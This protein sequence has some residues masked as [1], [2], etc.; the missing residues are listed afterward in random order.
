[1][2][3]ASSIMCK[4]INALAVLFLS[5]GFTVSA[6]NINSPYS[7]YGLGDILPSQNILT[8]GMGGIGTA[9]YDYRSVNFLNPASYGQLQTVMLDFG[10]EV[11]NLTIRALNPTRKYSNASPIISYLNLGIPL[12]KKKNIK[13]GG[14]EPLLGMVVGLRPM[15][16]VNYKIQR[17][18]K[19]TTGTLNDSVGT[20]FEGTGGSQQVYTG[21]GLKLKDLTIGLN[22]G[23][24]FGSK[25][26]STR[27]IFINDTVPYYKSNDQTTSN[28]NGFLF[29]AGAQYTFKL[30]K[31]MFL[32]VGAQ[33][34]WQQ[35]V[36]GNRD[37]IVETFDY[38]ANSATYR[39]D[40]VYAEKDV[41]G[42]VIMPAS[43]S[44]G[45]ILD[46]Q[47]KWSVGADYVSTKWTNHKFFDDAPDPLQDSW[48]MR[49]G[50]QLF[51]TPGKSYW[52]NVAYRTGFS[53]GKDYVKVGNELPK[54]T[55]SVGAGLP[56]RNVPYTNQSTIIN[57]AL[58]FGQ[59]GND[60]N[61][62]K[63]SFF[64]VS[65]GLSMSD[66]WFIKRKYD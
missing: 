8:R 26:F 20:I 3:S 24:L 65:V 27:R 41:K 19:L 17:I 6:Q 1:M 4:R 52:S 54:W 51:P 28:Y 63:E 45:A 40:S 13:T 10:V 57:T 22:I 21:F 30:N 15:T 48:E 43:F 62:V 35:T 46:N 38:D 61:S 7:R 14:R 49:I 44:I 18:E 50:G 37:V 42:D 60:K 11:D 55:F 29:N 2:Q 32:R 9:Y 39:I 12:I 23:Y 36:R 31:D 33:G 25:D 56:L 47:G 64:R 66:I 59:R 5:F 53:Y 16:R 34:N 58:E